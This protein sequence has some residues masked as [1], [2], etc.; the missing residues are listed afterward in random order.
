MSFND[1]AL[2]NHMPVGKILN[3]EAPPSAH[4]HWPDLDADL[5]IEIIEYADRFPQKY[6][7]NVFSG[8]ATTKLVE[9]SQIASSS[10]TYHVTLPNAK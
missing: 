3:A 8:Y 5:S 7:K 6:Q 2:F 10:T 9:K 1:F 4:F